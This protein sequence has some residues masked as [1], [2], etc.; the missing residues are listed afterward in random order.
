M[1]LSILASGLL[2]ATV[3]KKNISFSSG[4]GVS[5]FCDGIAKTYECMAKGSDKGIGRE[6]LVARGLAEWLSSFNGMLPFEERS[7]NCIQ[8]KSSTQDATEE[9]V[10]LFANI[11]QGGGV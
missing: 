8:T 7:W 2:N 3:L 9:M 10:I 6:I 4:S 11:L 1:A 5:V